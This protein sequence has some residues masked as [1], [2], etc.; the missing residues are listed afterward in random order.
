[1]QTYFEKA[2]DQLKNN[3]NGLTTLNLE[4]N[5]IGAA[6]ANDLAAALEK[7]TSLTMLDLGGNQ[8]DDAGAKDLAAALEKNISLTTLNLQFNPIGAAGAKDLA[9]ALEKNT[10]L[11]A[12]NLA[13]NQIYAAGA[14]DLAAALEKNTSLTMLNLMGNRIGFAGAKDL[15]AALEKNTSLTTLNLQSN[16]I[17]AAGAKDLAVALE[18]NTGLTALNLRLNLIYAD[19]AR[20]LAA[21]LEKNT[22]LTTLN[23]VHNA[24]GDAGAKDLATALEKNASLTTLNLWDNQ[25]GDAGA[26]DL[27]NALKNNYTLVELDGVNHEEIQQYLERNKKIAQ[28]LSPLNEALHKGSLL[29]DGQTIETCLINLENA[30]PE[31]KTLSEGS[32]PRE[33]HRLLNALG[34]SNAF[35][36]DAQLNALHFLLPSFKHQ[37]LQLLADKTLGLLLSGDFSNTLKEGRLEKE[38]FLLSLHSFRNHLQSPE[39]KMFVQLALFKLT[40]AND[41]AYT[42]QE[43]QAF[44]TD[45]LLLTQKEF[46]TFLNKA[47]ED[48]TDSCETLLLKVLLQSSCH[49]FSLLTACQSKAF[50]NAFKAKYPKA[51]SFTTTEHCLLTASNGNASFLMDI[52]KEP[53]QTITEDHVAEYAQQLIQDKSKT[54][55]QVIAQLKQ[56]LETTFLFEPSESKESIANAPEISQKIIKVKKN[57]QATSIALQNNDPVA[58]QNAILTAIKAFCI[59]PGNETVDGLVK[60][61]AIFENNELN[62]DEKINQL[63]SMAQ[64]NKSDYDNIRFF[65]KEIS[66]RAPEVEQ[67]YKTL[68]SLDTNNQTAIEDFIKQYPD[69]MLG[70]SIQSVL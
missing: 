54:L 22:S 42:L 35:G 65:H 53:N 31:L 39:I 29:H 61:K 26:K 4:N 38:G 32:Y 18:K 58:R 66:A 49:A 59:K 68:G 21:A 45:T 36:K 37:G 15:A 27:A 44:E 41:Q 55:D 63:I 47:L 46:T 7:N 64:W 11:T 33:A 25:I 19:G 40:H 43:K 34:Y 52:T 17:R 6:G 12:L 28:S 24:I 69:N 9:V 56:S 70:Q 48:K 30:I 8:I 23:L 51:K 62:K 20:D 13:N 57:L 16:A 60:M 67:F 5:Q 50:V 10:S 14:K 3:D 2:L 1:M